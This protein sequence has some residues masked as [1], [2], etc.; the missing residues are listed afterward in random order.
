[1]LNRMEVVGGELNAYTTKEDTFVYT[2]FM[3]EHIW[4]AVDLL[5]DIV[6]HSTF[7][8]AELEKEIDV[9][10]DEINSYKDNPSDLIFDDFEN[11][12]FRGHELGHHILGDEESVQRFTSETVI[13]FTRRLYTPQ[14]MVFFSCG[15]LDFRKLTAQMESFMAG[16]SGAVYGGRRRA[17]QSYEPQT[18]YVEKDTFQCHAVLGNRAYGL[19][20]ERER[21]AFYLLNNILGGPGM[22]S[23]L[24]VS[25]RE[26]MGLVYTVESSFVPFT[27]TGMF[28]VYFGC[29]PKNEE[30]CL[31]G[32]RKEL[33]RFCDERLSASQ[34]QAAKRQMYGQMGVAT[35][36]RESLALGM[37]K[38]FLR[39]QKYDS[40][41][42]RFARIESITTSDLLEV[43]NRVFDPTQLTTLIYK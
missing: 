6:F 41:E 32:V 28:S 22:N 37:G 40:L 3:A 33:R 42:T 18:L 23:R 14:R 35:D 15:N 29:D 25:L 1:M 43:A 8:E 2:V 11:M 17:P 27:D 39:F 9:V 4:R 10:L 21:T 34:L 19:D 24:N 5:T 13:S 16:V 31:G 30:R 7:P 36:N 38:S 12:L 20:E 26:R